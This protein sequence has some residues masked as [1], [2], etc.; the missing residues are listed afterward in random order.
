MSRPVLA[1]ALCLAFAACSK[2]ATQAGRRDSGGP[3][4]VSVAEVQAVPWER[5]IRLVG[6]L[7]ANQEARIAAEVEG[8]IEKTFVEVGDTVAEG[9][10]L[11]QIDAASYQGMVNLHTANLAKAQAN[12]EK[13][14]SNLD[15]LNQL[16]RSGV[17]AP[18]DYDE[19]VA[20]EKQAAAEVA[21]AKAQL[22]S[23]NTA[24]R[25]STARA[26]FN[27]AITERLVNAG[28]FVR[29][30]TVMF[31]IVDDS[32]LR[33][34]GEVPERVAAKIKTGQQV[35]LRVDA[36]PERVFEGRVS[37]I[38]PAVNPATRSVGLEALVPNADRAL[39]ANFFARAELVLEDST[40][41]LVV[42]IEAILT[43]AGVSK[44]FVVEKDTAQPR[45]LELGATRGEQQEVVGG[46]Q[47]GERVVVSGRTKVQAGTPVK[48]Q[49]K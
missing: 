4:N 6:T 16:K 45:E 5:T 9:R 3:V 43:F 10:E 24:L 12:A 39:K 18:T 25:R 26:P 7:A 40:P 38:N 35:R 42:P 21:A 36:Y 32:V 14:A 44:V 46:L 2:P 49:A 47:V 41:A 13:A 37:W 19:A 8:S 31:H 34:R 1:C 29:I 22:G 17:A 33:F 20:A 11:A 23:A 27:G 28:D 48:I 30:S 15:R